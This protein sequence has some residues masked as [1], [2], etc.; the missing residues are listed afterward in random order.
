MRACV[1][2]ILGTVLIAA[3]VTT[4]VVRA[5]SIRLRNGDHL[6]GRITAL[7][8]DRVA[9]TTQF[10]GGIVIKLSTV[11][12]MQSKRPLK[13][14]AKNKLIK[15][16]TISPAPG[17]VGWIIHPVNMAE[18]TIPVV[19]PPLP[20][21]PPPPPPPPPPTSIFGPFWDNQLDIGGTNTTGNADSSQ[22]TG[23]LSFHYVRKPDNLLLA[24][25]GGYG[26][27]NSSESLGFFNSNILWKRRLNELM[28]K[29]AKKIFLFT[30]NTN[31]YNA[32]E[33]LSLRSDTEGGLGYYL[34]SNHKSE[35]DL[36]I[37]PGYTYARYFH[38]Q[39][40]NYANAS[41]AL[42]FMYRIDRNVKFTQ[43][44]DYVTSLENVQN[45][46]INSSSNGHVGATS[47]LYIGLPQVVRG[48][49]LQFSFTDMY[50][51]TAGM[52]G[53]NR[54]STLLVAGMTFKF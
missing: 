23:S 17:N 16:V 25:S 35:F 45:Y 19:A 13:W 11:A 8:P 43:T 21:M 22:F 40:F 46:Q 20:L 29:W 4:P 5:G 7:T 44:A 6:T 26:V 10:A 37:G 12:T 34:W 30:Q 47:A 1:S 33:G 52:Q 24:F 27:T 2:Y 50:D 36:R 54:N 18:K 53:Y 49:G 31:M 3:A 39:T 38:G 15:Q 32:I 9:V 48:M 14:I 28:P 51:N 41:A 42:H